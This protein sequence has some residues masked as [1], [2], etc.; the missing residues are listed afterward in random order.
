MSFHFIKGA[1]DIEVRNPNF[2]DIRRIA[3]NDIRRRTRN[4]DLKVFADAGWPTMTIH[5]YQFS[6]L[7]DTVASP[8]ITELRAF[9]TATAG[10][11]IAI[12]DQYGDTYL[13]VIWTPVPEIINT[14]PPCSYDLSFEFMRNMI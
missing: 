5:V 4:G 8:Q 9:F 7:R 14:R 1:T 3:Q 6:R 2:G 11:E 12:T 10:L 13:G